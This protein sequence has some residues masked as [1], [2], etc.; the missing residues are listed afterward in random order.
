M[1]GERRIGGTPLPANALSAHERKSTIRALVGKGGHKSVFASRRAYPPY[2]AVTF[3]SIAGGSLSCLKTP[4]GLLS[5]SPRKFSA[6]KLRPVSF[7]WKSLLWGVPDHPLPHCRWRRAEPDRPGIEAYEA[8]RQ[9]T[10]LLCRPS[11]L[12]PWSSIYENG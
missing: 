6:P 11:R 12:H 2:C 8:G 5:S 3:Q 10:A 4:D 1:S 9:G 7:K